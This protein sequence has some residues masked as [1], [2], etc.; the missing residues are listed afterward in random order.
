MNPRSFFVGRAV[1]LSVLLVLGALVGGFFWLNSYIYNEKQHGGIS[2][3]NYKEISYTIEG[4]QVQLGGDT[5]Y[6]GNE[7]MGDLNGDGMP[8]VAFLVTAQP[9]GSGT[10]YYVVVALRQA[11]NQYVGTNGVLLGDRI[12]PQTTEI[13]G[14]SLIVN[15]ADRK[16]N[17]PMVT[18]PSVGVSKYLKVS[19]TQLV[20]TAR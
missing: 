15:Y 12:A 7:A 4:R 10:F 18:P 3:K 6:F 13:S 16:P 1:V 11:D 9:G 8:D 19:G 17:E 20:E 2:L 5:K 14:D